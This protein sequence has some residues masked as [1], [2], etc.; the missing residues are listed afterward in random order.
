M[1]QSW[2]C[3]RLAGG[4]KVLYCIVF[5]WLATRENHC[6]CQTTSEIKWCEKTRKQQLANWLLGL[7]GSVSATWIKLYVLSLPSE[8]CALNKHYGFPFKHAETRLGQS[9]SVQISKMTLCFVKYK[10]AL[11]T[12]RLLLEILRA[13]FNV[14]GFFCF[15]LNGASTES[16]P[17]FATKMYHRLSIAQDSRRVSPGLTINVNFYTTFYQ[18]GDNHFIS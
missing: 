18:S 10:V 3:R 6:I 16:A 7:C 12:K 9:G 8:G 4:Q 11:E 17:Y 2:F 14:L 15:F 5:W 1:C 13:R